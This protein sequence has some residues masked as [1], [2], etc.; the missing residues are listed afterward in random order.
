MASPMQTGGVAAM[1]LQ[2]MGIGGGGGQGK[3]EGAG[4]F[5]GRGL[6]AAGGFFGG[7]SSI[8]QWLSLESG[9]KGLVV[10]L[11]EDSRGVGALAGILDIFE[12]SDDA[13]SAF[14]GGGAA[15][16]EGGGGASGDSGE[17]PS[18]FSSFAGN[19]FPDNM[20]YGGD[21]PM[22][23]MGNLAPDST[24]S[25]GIGGREASI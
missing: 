15:S 16:F 14:G 1:G 18:P 23:R 17:A 5:M 7:D 24:P 21:V 2:G 3:W 22:G 9:V 19:V 6:A 11:Y 12:S 8:G 10:A 13:S 25:A 20:S 4:N